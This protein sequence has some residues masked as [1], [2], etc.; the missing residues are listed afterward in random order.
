MRPPD[1]KS[2]Q[3][4]LERE[5]LDAALAGKP[6]DF[7]P[8]MRWGVSS[9]ATANHCRSTESNWRLQRTLTGIGR[10]PVICHLLF[11]S[12]GWRLGSYLVLRLIPLS[13]LEEPLH[14]NQGEARIPVCQR[15]DRKHIVSQKG[16]VPYSRKIAYQMRKEQPMQLGEQHS[17]KDHHR[18]CSFL[19]HV[20]LRQIF[21]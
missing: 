3:R 1:S 16:G 13:C 11:G 21:R 9:S 10:G 5:F 15:H 19:M 8:R 6:S 14:V 12:G 17:R 4:F 7:S 2:K 20:V 18:R